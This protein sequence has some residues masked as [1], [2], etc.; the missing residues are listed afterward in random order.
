M[1]LDKISVTQVDYVTF[2][3]LWI[4]GAAMHVAT[5]GVFGLLIYTLKLSNENTNLKEQARVNDVG[6]VRK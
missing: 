2:F 4:E 5:F 3:S 1:K 6:E